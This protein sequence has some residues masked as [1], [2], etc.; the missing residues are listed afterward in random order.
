MNELTAEQFQQM[1]AE[2]AAKRQ[3]ADVERVGKKDIK[4][5][6]SLRKIERMHEGMELKRE[7]NR[8]MRCW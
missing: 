8:I 4:R 7:I 5:G 3:S 6:D 2:K 1:L